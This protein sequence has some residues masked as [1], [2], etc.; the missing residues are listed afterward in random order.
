MKVLRYLAYLLMISAFFRVIPVITALVY[1]EPFISFIIS[2]GVSFFFG[3]GLWYLT[4]A[5]EHEPALD[6]TGGL[7]LVALSFIILPVFGAISFLPSFDYSFIDATFESVSGFT[8][9]GMTLYDS[10]DGLPKSLL[11]WRALTQWLGGI[12]IIMVFLFIFSRLR[13]H[14]FSKL[15][16]AEEH[17]STTSALYQAQGFTEK[18]ETGMKNTTRSIFII[19]LSYTVAG[20]LFLYAAG[21]RLFDS[22]A[23]T[24]TSLSTGGFTVSDTFYTNDSQLWVLCGLMVLGAI[25]FISHNK[26]VQLKF[27]DFL[28]TLEK[29]LFLLF[30]GLSIVLVLF[31]YP[32]LKTVIFELV[33]AFTTTG[34]SM[35]TIALLPQLFILVI[36]VGMLVGG[37]VASTAGGIKVFRIY[38]LVKSIPWILKKLSSPRKAIIPFR[39]QDKQVDESNV[40]IIGVFVFCYFLIILVGTIVFLLF[41]YSFLD[42]SFQMISALG[43][44]GLQTT[45]LASVP[46]LGKVILMVA[47]IF[48]RLEIF[49][50]LVLIRSFFRR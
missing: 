11:M 13:A 10:L 15:T 40:L 35:T 17:M 4:R 39:I 46:A 27:K 25:S 9:T 28:K 12:G 49:P 34:Y 29:N 3:L 26:L 37:C 18:A 38:T 7:M 8:T 48:G 41:G 16:E 6:L 33:S 23:M 44:V 1:D 42:S 5:K 2:A 20:T 36:M 14:A 24:F 19:Y 30:L 45:S 22:I 21:M 50:V 31:A 43:T 47:M 32:D